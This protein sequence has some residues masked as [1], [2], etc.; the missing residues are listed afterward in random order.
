LL[1]VAGGIAA[2]SIG[3]VLCGSAPLGRWALLC[4]V[5]AVFGL[6]GLPLRIGRARWLMRLMYAIGGSALLALSV[7]LMVDRGGIA[8]YPADF[9]YQLVGILCASIGVAAII[10]VWISGRSERSEKASGETALDPRSMT[11]GYQAISPPAKASP[12]VSYKSKAVGQETPAEIQAAAARSGMIVLAKRYTDA[13]LSVAHE[14][15]DVPEVM[16]QVEAFETA[17]FEPPLSI[18]IFRDDATIRA[19]VQIGCRGFVMAATEWDEEAV[20]IK[21]ISCL[22]DGH[23]VLTSNASDDQED[24]SLTHSSAT[25]LTLP[26][27]DAVA[28]LQ[29]HL[30]HVEEVAGTRGQ[31]MVELEFAEWRDVLHCAERC[32]ADVLHQC[33]RAN[34]DIAEMGYGRFSFPPHP[35]AEPVGN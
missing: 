5:A 17:Q 12:V 23:M 25:L 4:P 31:S 8:R 1:W 35:I 28:L 7:Y 16:V 22:A 30:Q 2:L 26:A 9:A 33:D 14:A 21:L 19:T 27:Q 6:A 13:R 15:M 10:G 3:L 32:R 11:A 18:E 29:Q 24:P 20:R 34:F